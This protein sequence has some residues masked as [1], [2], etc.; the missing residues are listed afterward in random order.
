MTTNREETYVDLDHGVDGC[1]IVVCRDCCCG[2]T[3]KHPSTEH[4]KH[5]ELLRKAA[6]ERTHCNVRVSR[7]LSHC[8]YSNVVVVRPHGRNA[9]RRA[10]WFGNLHDDLHVEVLADWIRAGGPD[11]SDVPEVLLTKLIP[12][13]NTESAM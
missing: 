8:S 10:K 6:S 7:C 4:D 3:R 1:T 13:L 5:L 12:M 9:H 11:V 2:S